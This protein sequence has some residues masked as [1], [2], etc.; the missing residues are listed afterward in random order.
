MNATCKSCGNKIVIMENLRS[1]TTLSNVEIQGNVSVDGGSIGLGPGGGIAF[2]AGGK[3]GFGAAK[4][5]RLTCEKCGTVGKY[6]TKEGKQRG[7]IVVSPSTG[8]L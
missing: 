5:L 8:S 2:K 3:I 7:T 1:N 6:L 4:H